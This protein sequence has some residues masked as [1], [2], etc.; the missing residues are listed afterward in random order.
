LRST[1]LS[2]FGPVVA[3]DL[4][5]ALRG[6][7][8]SPAFLAVAIVSLAL[9]IG[10]NIAIV[11]FVNALFFR[12]L[13][14][15]VESE[16]LG[17]IYHRTG[18]GDFTSSSYPDYLYYQEGT[19][20]CSG[21]LAY[22]R[23]PVMLRP[24]AVAER[25][26]AELVSTN[27]FQ[28]L[29]MKPS[30]GR[31]FASGED[32]PSIVLAD[33]FWRARFGA[34][35]GIV[36]RS[37]RLGSGTFTVIGVAPPGFR[38]VV[39]DWAETPLLWLPV[40]RYREAVAPFRDFDI[41]GSWGMQS[42]QIVARLRPGATFEQASSELAA[43]SSR[44]KVEHPE[45]AAALRDM[46]AYGETSPVLYPTTRTRFWPGARGNVVSFLGLLSA[47]AVLILLVAVANVANLVLTRATA[48]RSEFALKLALGAGRGRIV[49]QL[50]VENLVLAALGG[51]A[52]LAVAG[53]TSRFL[54]RFHQAFLLPLDVDAGFDPAVLG[55]AAALTVTVGVLLALF[56]LRLGLHSGLSGVIKAETGTRG[57]QRLRTN[58]LLVAAQV[59]VSVVLVIGAGLFVKTLRNAQAAD[60]TMRSQD[61]LLSTVD[62]GSR[63]YDEVRGSALYAQILDRVRSLPGVSD[64]AFVF[65]VPLGGR[66]GGTNVVLNSADGTSKSLQ[67]GFNV[68]T[69]GYFR[70]VGIPVLRGRD[71]SDTDRTG[72]A[73]VAMINEE[74]AKRVFAGRDPVGER[75]LLS[76]RPAAIVQVV[77]VVRDGKFRNYR[78]PSEPTVYVPLGQRYMPEMNLEVRASGT[79]TGLAGAVRTSIAALDPDLPVAGTKTLR[80]HLEDAL[81][82]ERLTAW[83]LSAL[84]AL[85]LVLAAVG[86]Y[87]VQSY[88]VEQRT[89]EVGIRMALGARSRDVRRS[90]TAAALVPVVVGLVLGAAAAAALGRV[91]GSLL[92]GVSPADPLLFGTTILFLLAVS[93]FAAYVPAWRAA[94]VDPAIALRYE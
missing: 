26:S 81:S 5:L 66:R 93:W 19:R 85:A 56:P 57:V 78:T 59:A 65:V 11:S 1:S 87:G 45:R 63:D 88:S 14:G 21:M 38:G 69:P 41:L 10:V 58:R 22:L 36:G 42:Y 75:F 61:V 31:F 72:S 23:V 24:D 77:G 28:V 86:V 6:F 20:T 34:D 29:G 53:A 91:T 80:G 70:T 9:G 35:P 17:S 15:T 27:Y 2:W 46:A 48:R 16:R 71:F 82:Q 47:V 43:L 94:R 40:S 90:V 25:A 68:V 52:G 12:S 89:R 83:L 33:Q 51:V 18:S 79:I 54:A 13:P 84:G 76:W 74:M 32:E 49:S 92:Y 60:V 64:A 67:V 37:L 3:R 44:L 55:F 50:L 39:L 62:L 4:K 73:P 7:R 8:R 30:L